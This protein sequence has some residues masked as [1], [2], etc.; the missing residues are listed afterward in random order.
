MKVALLIPTCGYVYPQFLKRVLPAVSYA[1]QQ[2]IEISQVGVTERMLVHSARNQLAKGFMKT[3]CDWAFWIDDDTVLPYNTIP[4]LL[5]LAKEKD[6]K[7]VS[8]VYYQRLPPHNPVLWRKD[9]ETT[10]GLRIY[11]EK[12][13]EKG[14]PVYT[15]HY[16]SPQLNAKNPFMADV[17]GFGCVMTHREMFEKIP[18]PW[19]QMITGR[20]SEDFFFCVEAKKAGYQLWIDP[21]LDLGHIGPNRIIYR[22][23]YFE[24]VDAMGGQFNQIKL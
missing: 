5:A 24:H 4:K 9:P 21:S 8:G 10:E 1:S 3:D 12:A 15:H 17:A 20:C 22:K 18:E 7:F 14:D 6:T 13:A 16:V 2:G 19:F 11:S 23:D